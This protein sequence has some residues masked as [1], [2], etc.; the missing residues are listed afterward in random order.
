MLNWVAKHLRR[1][2][3]MAFMS[4]PA[5]LDD[6]HAFLVSVL[7]VIWEVLGVYRCDIDST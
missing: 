6:M 5:G 2:D 3:S 7:E 4:A 1:F